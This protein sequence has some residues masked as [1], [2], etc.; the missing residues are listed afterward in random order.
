MKFDAAG[1]LSEDHQQNSQA[2]SARRQIGWS[3][4]K[5]PGL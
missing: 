3:S 4:S 2:R 1:A 5:S